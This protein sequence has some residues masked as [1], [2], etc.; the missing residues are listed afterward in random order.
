MTPRIDP[1]HPFVRSIASALKT[2]CGVRSEARL[3]LA[4]S[5]GADSVAL[6]L[7]VATLAPKRN[8]NLQPAIAHVQHRLRHDGSAESDAAFTASLADELSLPFLNAT[9]DSPPERI[10]LEAWA[11]RAR[12]DA[13]L[14]MAQAFDA[15]FI[16]T[17]HHADDQLET[18]L[19]RLLRGA[20]IRGLAGMAWRRRMAAVPS[21]ALLLRPMLGIT[22]EEA[23][24]FLRDHNQ[25]WREDPTNADTSRLRARLR[26]QVL[27]A[28]I[29][30]DARFP[31]RATLA[32]DHLRQ[33]S[34]LVEA[35][36]SSAAD[37]VRVIE[38]VATL[39]RLDARTMPRIVLTGLLRRM[40]HEA[41]AALD[42]L[43][44]R[45][46]SPITR[47]ARDREGGERLFTLDAGIGVTINAF[48]VT[49]KPGRAQDR[50]I[51]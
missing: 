23:R 42:Q 49:I 47:A 27:P 46:L 6:A 28:L 2:R 12:Y 32:A 39:D 37:R 7:A 30:A 35:A 4:V 1:N 10:N 21:T 9:L 19:M 17:A 25:A 14:T 8:W 45:A 16:A 11:R 34:R 40:A 43:G 38:G 51:V 48:V 50:G 3:V 18:L 13:L 44:N 36:I 20:S 24:Q 26:A 31:A 33:A 29:A 5:G 15:P 41:G 22:R